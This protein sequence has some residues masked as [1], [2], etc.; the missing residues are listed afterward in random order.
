MSP[1][2]QDSVDAMN[3]PQCL[4]HFSLGRWLAGV[5]KKKKK[6]A[7]KI[8]VGKTTGSRVV[9]DEEGQALQ[10]LAQ[11]ALP[12]SNECANHPFYPLQL[13]ACATR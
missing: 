11:L 1:G 3:M 7:L 9:F 5:A 12:E 8:K 2:L 13:T 10:P 4:R 6:K